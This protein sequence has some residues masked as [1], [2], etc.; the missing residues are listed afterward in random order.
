MEHH[1]YT[2]QSSVATFFRLW[3]Y[4]NITWRSCCLCASW[5]FASWSWRLLERMYVRSKRKN[6]NNWN[7]V[8]AICQYTPDFGYEQVPYRDHT[9]YFLGQWLVATCPRRSYWWSW[10]GWSAL[11]RLKLLAKETSCCYS[12]S[13]LTTSRFLW[14]LNPKKN[15][16]SFS[17]PW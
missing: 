6:P 5:L 16:F 11:I 10:T 17:L 12:N 8:E 9:D 15:Y 4:E 7:H 1:T 13:K 14:N 2:W 3:A